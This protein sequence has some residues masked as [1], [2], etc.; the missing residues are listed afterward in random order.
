MLA[1][2]MDRNASPTGRTGRD[3]EALKGFALHD[4]KST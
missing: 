4:V 1:L 2:E 3:H